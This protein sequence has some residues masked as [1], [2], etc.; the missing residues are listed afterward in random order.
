MRMRPLKFFF[1]KKLFP[2]GKGARVA[3]QVTAELGGHVSSSTLNARQTAR[4]RVAA[5]SSSAATAIAYEVEHVE[6]E[7][8]SWRP[9]GTRLDSGLVAGRR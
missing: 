5:H 2:E 7:D 6:Y 8:V 9:N 1:K 3:W 4:A